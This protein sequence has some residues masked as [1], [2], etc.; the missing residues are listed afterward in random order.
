VSK[1]PVGPTATQFG[2]VTF[3]NEATVDFDL[4]QLSTADQIKDKVSNIRYKDENT[5]TSGGIWVRVIFII[6]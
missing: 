4:N 3:G 6:D 2:S 5:N 1:F